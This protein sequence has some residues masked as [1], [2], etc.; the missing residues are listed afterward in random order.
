VFVFAFNGMGPANGICDLLRPVLTGAGYA[1][2]ADLRPGS[3]PR[4][5]FAAVKARTPASLKRAYYG[6]L[7]EDLT[8][9]TAQ[10]LP[11]YDWSAT[12]AF[13]MPSEQH[14]WIRLNVAGREA[15][16][17][18]DPGAYERTCDELEA[19]LRSL[20][21]PSGEPLVHEIARTGADDVLP[22]LV[23]FWTAAAD[24]E[25]ARLDGREFRAPR[26]V[27]WLVGQHTNE[28]FCLAPPHRTGGRARIAPVEMQQL[29]LD[30]G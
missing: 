18:V 3:V 29:M 4:R 19:M 16:G 13:A 30:P 2:I 22:D 28:G 24:G 8:L 12:R 15:A 25:V 27:P 9:R 23:V 11:D 26:I 14:G 1:R 17:I 20:T 21:S 10:M 5:T 6:L 7:P